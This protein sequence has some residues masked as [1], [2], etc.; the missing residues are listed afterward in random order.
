MSSTEKGK[1]SEIYQQDILAPK[2][3]DPQDF[4]SSWVECN[5]S[6]SYHQRYRTR[7][8][9]TVNEIYY[10]AY[11]P[12]N[13]LLRIVN[14]IVQ[15]K[16]WCRWRL[17][18]IRAPGSGEAVR[19]SHSMKKFSFLFNETARRT[20]GALN[21]I[22]KGFVGAGVLA[23]PQSFNNAGLL[24]GPIMVVVIGFIATHCLVILVSGFCLLSQC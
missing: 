22:L 12:V 1:P 10:A 20:F 11:H 15:I 13:L 21:H 9:Q 19:V 7:I 6:F 23:I 8:A 24:F 14:I 4:N 17:Q 18:S 5:S 3:T 2:V 16:T